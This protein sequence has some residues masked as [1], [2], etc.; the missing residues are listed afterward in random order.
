MC[1]KNM[2]LKII[3]TTM[4]LKKI[5]PVTPSYRNLIQIN[6]KHLTK[7]FEIK[8]KIIGLKN[9]SGRNNSGKI[10]S[11]RKG[12]GHKQKYRNINFFRTQ[13]SIGIITSIEYDPNRNANIAS[14]F[15]ISKKHYFYIL[16]PTNLK[17]GNIIKTGANAEPKIGHSL[18]ISNIP[19]GCCIHNVSPKTKKK[20]QISRAAG[21]FSSLTEK[22][23]EYGRI[24]LSSGEQRLL[25]VNCFATIGIVSNQLNFLT[26][27]G[28]AGRSRWLN[29]RPTVRGVAMN[30]IDH[31]H[32][33]G[34]GKK[35]GIS[36][37]PWGKPTKS[38]FTSK[39]KNKLII[40]KKNE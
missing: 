12:G 27:L 32:G 4:N 10:T 30:P 40:N 2:I 9:S 21:T 8:S 16:A 15:D 19:V 26:K 17:I 7:T 39:S 37:T 18:T 22:T 29:R 20:A 35:S 36:L 3:F 5:R 1:D 13:D 23:A 38:G 31:P 11:F 14:V 34:E 33:G 24:E 6:N 25:S 28:K